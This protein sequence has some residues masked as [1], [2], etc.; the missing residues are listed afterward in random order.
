M[1]KGI[2]GRRI[3]AYS[4]QGKGRWEKIVNIKKSTEKS[5][6]KMSFF[7][8]L[9]KGRKTSLQAKELTEVLLFP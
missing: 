8:V 3:E 7:D 9:K 4:N 5:L 2:V 1:A 6:S